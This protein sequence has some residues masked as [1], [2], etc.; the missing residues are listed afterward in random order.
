MNPNNPDCKNCVFRL[1]ALSQYKGIR[2]SSRSVEHPYS[3]AFMK[4]NGLRGHKKRTCGQAIKA[5]RTA[6]GL[7]RRALSEMVETYSLQY[8]V[9]FTV[10]DIAAYE[11]RNVNP[12]IDKLTALC[13]ATQMPLAF[14]TGYR[15]SFKK[16]DPTG[17]AMVA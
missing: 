12:K 1:A 3:S 11:L 10:S 9:R 13:H 6:G 15:K 16:A 8:N 5:F 4:M 17:V 7:S 14:F 2:Y